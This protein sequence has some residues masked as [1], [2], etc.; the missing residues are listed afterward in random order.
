VGTRPQLPGGPYLVVGLA[1]SGIAAA[2][3]LSA[4]GEE[5]LGVDSRD[6]GELRELRDRGVELRLAERAED[7][8]ALLERARTLVKSPG[9]PAQA[10]IVSEARARG[11]AVMGELELG[12]RLLP[13]EFI[14]VTGTNGKT[15]TV[16]LV[17]HTL[18]V[19]R[20]AASVAGNVGTAL[21]S[22]VGAIAPADVIVCEVSSFQL[23][24]ALCFA[25]ETAVLLNLAP[26]HLDRHGSMQEY[27]AAK[28]RIFAAQRDRAVAVVPWALRE[29][30]AR[31]LAGNPARE[32]RV[33][34]FG[35]DEHAEL[36]RRDGGLWW[37]G[38]ELLGVAELRLRGA[39]NA[40]NAMAAA[41][42]CLARGTPIEAVREGLRSF[43]GVA[44]RL[45]EVATHAGVVYVN[46]SKATN[47]AST[48]VALEAFPPEERIHL[49]LGGQGKGQDFSPLRAPVERACAAV[50]LIGEDAPA[51]A[52]A[53]EG[54][55]P[56]VRESGELER[57]V[58]ACARAAKAGDVVLLS[59]ACASFDQF[60]DFEA[61]GE[62]FRGLV[63]AL[64]GAGG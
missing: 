24:D 14:A 61:R 20:V 38:E 62:R 32:R 26:D 59:P 13:N 17:A 11:M 23:E 44:H 51:I 40:E 35:G 43:A 52:R 28:L 25:P 6:I 55:A 58:S 2:L 30:V 63:E 29:L 41:A 18:R 57:A 60:A 37:Q 54:V 45:E 48:I 1:R 21:C 34:R 56:P 36:C 31:A 22:L 47:V 4:R 49:I 64:S 50:Y 7:A 33:I 3:A 46:D 5:V 10:P 9:V 19:A 8:P 39:H 53:L 42:A 27:E 16:E 12:W 15:T